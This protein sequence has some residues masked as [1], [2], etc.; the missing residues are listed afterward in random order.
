MKGADMNRRVDILQYIKTPSGRWQWAPIPKNPRT[1]ACLW[2]KV[3]SDQFYIVWR[4]QGKRRYEK[5]GITPSEAL[6]AKRRK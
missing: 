4:E 2:S 6:E 3:Q 1:G 5:A